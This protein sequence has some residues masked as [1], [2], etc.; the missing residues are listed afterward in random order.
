MTEMKATQVTLLT[1][2]DCAYCEHAKQVLAKVAHDH[3]LEVTEI[4]LDTPEGERLGAQARVLF[5][6]GVLLDGRPFAHGRLSERAL[7]KA[8]SRLDAR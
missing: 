3:L 2:A 5:A 6:P 1:K 7:R 8:L 4:S